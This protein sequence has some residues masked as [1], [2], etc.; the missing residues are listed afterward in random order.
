MRN[1]KFISEWLEKRN[2]QL[3]AGFAEM[4]RQYAKAYKHTHNINLSEIYSMLGCS[5]Q[6]VSY[7]EIHCDSTQSGSSILRVVRGAR[8]LFGLT[9][10]E[11]EKLANSAGLSL[12]SEGGSLMETLKYCG[13]ICELSANALISERMLRHYKKNPYKTGAYGNNAFLEYEP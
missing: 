11:A 12:Y 4:L 9:G 13:K 7:W 2:I 5:K 3:A 8:E 10:D 1:Y 6:N